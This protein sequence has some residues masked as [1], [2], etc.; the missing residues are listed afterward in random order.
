MGELLLIRHG[1]TAWSRTGQYAGRTDVPMT[2]AGRAAARRLAPVFA[3]R[4]VVAALTSPA[5]RAVQTAGLIGLTGLRADPDLWEWD[6]GG[7]E[8]LTAEQISAARPGWNLWRDGV[9]PGDAGHP[10]E[11]VAEVGA[12]VD[13]V[14]DRVRPLLADGDVALVLHGHLQR[15]LAARW[16]GLPPEAG[17][18]LRHPGTGTLSSLGTEHD[19]PVIGTW[20][21]PA[22]A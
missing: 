13:A 6:Y 1:E 21:V 9:V 19:E 12:R 3:P 8:G 16:L 22:G 4:D 14:L 17:R 7:Y 18:L 10:G 2:E 11:S 20:N 15:V 5:G